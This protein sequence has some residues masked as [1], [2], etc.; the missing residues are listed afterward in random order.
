M[1][2]HY[3]VIGNCLK[4]MLRLSDEEAIVAIFPLSTHQRLDH[5][6]KI[7]KLNGLP[8]DAQTALDE[9]RVVMTGIQYVRNN[10]VV[11]AIIV[12]DETEGR[13][14]HLR[15][16]RTFTHEGRGFATAEWTNYAAHAVL[17]LRYALGLKGADP[18]ARHPLPDRPEVPEFL[19]E[20]IPP[21]DQRCLV[22]L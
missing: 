9:L 19:R 13:V 16:K 20:L 1:V 15:S 10:N 22:T 7:A 14:F 8:A 3:H 21:R 11:H 2:A 17:S 4:A 6:K 18:G 5:M 12:D